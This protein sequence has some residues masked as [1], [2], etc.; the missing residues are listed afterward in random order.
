MTA[1]NKDAV[2]VASS[3]LSI[4]SLVL[5]FGVTWYFQSSLGLLQQQV[6]YDRELLL[7][8]QEQVNSQTGANYGN[9]NSHQDVKRQSEND[10]QCKDGAPGPAGE[11]GQ[12]GEPG[13]KG[14]R[15]QK[16]PQGPTGHPG[17]QGGL[18]LKGEQGVPGPAG[19]PGQKGDKGP[20][21]MK[22]ESGPNG[23]R[24]E[25]GN[26]GERG[27]NGLRGF[28][29]PKGELGFPGPQGEFGQKGERGIPGAGGPPGQK[30]PS[31][32]KGEPGP[33]GLRGEMGNKGERGNNGLPGLTGLKGELG[34]A[35]FP[36]Q[37][38][39][40]GVQGIPG[41][42]GLPG[43]KGDKGERVGG[44][45][46]VRWGHDGCS[47]AAQLVYSGRTGGADHKQG[48]A[49][50][51]QCLPLDPKFL[52]PISGNQD[53]RGLM[54][55]AEYEN[56]EGKHDSDVPCAVCYVT[57]RSTVYMLPAKFTC[58]SGWTRE[59]HGYLMSGHHG[60]GRLQFICVDMAFKSVSSTSANDNGVQLHPV[61]G[62]CGSLPCPPYD[63]TNE[64]S[65]AVC[66]K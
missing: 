2:L 52:T 46:Y 47:S 49:S 48:S 66:T 54:Y 26:K 34:Q 23:L 1:T 13:K 31:G 11:K 58:P 61:E 50:N 36:G 22:G 18:G 14:R 33:N 10:C 37:Q 43:Q 7:K 57:Q 65:C 16:G 15:G 53:Y 5:L 42:V 3:I 28:M 64:L 27:N 39:V 4:V 60:H 35:G 25:M 6:E 20:S 59:Y 55:G 38:G 41:T 24:G 62:R 40:K 21:G 51:P 29:G 8:L 32:M 44:A 45:L 63:N 9:T 12:P 56:I 30:G 17:P 19:P